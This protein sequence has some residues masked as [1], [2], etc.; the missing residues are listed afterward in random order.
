MG[1]GG[2]QFLTSVSDHGPKWIPSDCGK[3]EPEDNLVQERGE[4][5]N[6]DGSDSANDFLTI[7]LQLDRLNAGR[8]IHEFLTP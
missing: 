5:F 7:C 6:A 4:E 2:E 8:L 3:S 1:Y